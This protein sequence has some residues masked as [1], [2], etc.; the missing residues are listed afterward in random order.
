FLVHERPLPRRAVYNY[1]DATE[2]DAIDVT[3][4][5]VADRLA[6]QGEK[7]RPEAI[8]AHLEL[9]RTM[10]GEALDWRES[11]PPR[12]PLAGDDLAAELGIEPG[13]EL[14]RLLHELEAAVFAGDVTSRETAIAHA[15]DNLKQV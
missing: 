2:P 11:G 6:T 14:G 4:L 9:A 5:T 7:T 12:A 10:I 3:V 15:R 13:P 1:L 8:D